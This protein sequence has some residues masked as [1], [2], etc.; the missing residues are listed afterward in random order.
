MNKIVLD[1]HHNLLI[2]CGGHLYI[3]YIVGGKANISFYGSKKSYELTDDEN[4][5]LQDSI[6]LY[7]DLI[8]THIEQFANILAVDRFVCREFGE[9]H[10]MMDMIFCRLAFDNKNKTE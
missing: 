3:V 1:K 2:N 7:N 4:V 10:F 5:C 9:L 6:E 8:V